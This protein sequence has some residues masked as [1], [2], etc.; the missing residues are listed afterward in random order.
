MQTCCNWQG[1]GHTG[2]V[3]EILMLQAEALHTSGE[4]N[5]PIKRL[6]RALARAEPEGYIRLFVDEGVPMARLLFQLHARRKSD[7]PGSLGYQKSCWHCLAAHVEGLPHLAAGVAGL[8]TYPLSEP[9]SERELEVLR[10]IGAG[11]SDREIAD[12]S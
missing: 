2:S 9:L 3:I 1:A 10:L 6:S 11:F 5:Q 4:V 7:Q 12:G 8:Q